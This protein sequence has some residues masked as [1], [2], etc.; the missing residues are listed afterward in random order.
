MY[1]IMYICTCTKISNVSS[2]WE[3]IKYWENE[4]INGSKFGKIL[5]KPNLAGIF[6]FQT[7][8]WMRKQLEKVYIVV[9]T[10]YLHAAN[11]GLNI[12]RFTWCAD[13]RETVKPNLKISKFYWI[14][15][16][17]QFFSQCR[18]F[19]W[20]FP[21]QSFSPYYSS[22]I[23]LEV[24]HKLIMSL[25][26]NGKNR[27]S[28]IFSFFIC[29]N[30]LFCSSFLP[31]LFCLL[32]IYF[33]VCFFCFSCLFLLHL[34]YSQLWDSFVKITWTWVELTLSCSFSYIWNFVAIYLQLPFCYMFYFGFQLFLLSLYCSLGFSEIGHIKFRSWYFCHTFPTLSHNVNAHSNTVFTLCQSTV[35]LAL[36]HLMAP[37]IS[38]IGVEVE[39]K[40][41]LIH[42][43][44]PPTTP[45]KPTAR[46]SLCQHPMSRS[47]LCLT[48]SRSEQIM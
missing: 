31:F 28:L 22:E 2:A 23:L 13:T 24:S 19:L 33:A 15:C 21:C 4:R 9:M 45:V 20:L 12:S 35:F 5:R 39:R 40:G 7:V 47:H 10:S 32:F 48:I 25:W 18:E 8:Y 26:C 3:W 44:I 38:L 17:G 42:H 14:C 37:A 27:Q 6:L 30:L 11:D 41:S 46:T 34:T 1:V 43:V 29:F 16:T 36:L